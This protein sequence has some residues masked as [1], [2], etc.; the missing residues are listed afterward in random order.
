M[1]RKQTKRGRK[2]NIGL[3]KNIF[4]KKIKASQGFYGNIMGEETYVDG[5]LTINGK[6]TIDTDLEI[7][8]DLVVDGFI[9][10]KFLGDI[11]IHGNVCCDVSHAKSYNARQGLYVNNDKVV[12]H[13]QPDPGNIP[14]GATAAQTKKKLNQILDC[15]RAHGLI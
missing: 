7:G 6:T 4:G 15:L 13:R 9:S 14:P 3:G 12:A 2:R 5:E 11:E 10:G 1:K 8:Q